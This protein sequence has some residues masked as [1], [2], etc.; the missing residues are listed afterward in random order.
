M[1]SGS[2]APVLSDVM[3][4]E[5]EVSLR[6]A[7]HL[8]SH[9]KS[10][11]SA[12]VAID[13]AHVRVHGNEVFPLRSFL[14]S[15]GW[16]PVTALD[17]AL[18]Q[19]TYVKGQKKILITTQSGIGDVVIDVGPKTIRAECKKGPLI[20]KKGSPEYPLVRGAIG[21][22]MTIE[23]APANNLLVVAVPLTERFRK[24]LARWRDRPLIQR[25]G[26]LLVAVG[27]SETVEGLPPL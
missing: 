10:G 13:G 6:L 15:Q 14:E 7:F 26:I 1:S 18:W 5:A 23:D 17:A 2:S 25:T 12:T 3:M 19:G 21:Q 11:P 20:P 24:L 16:S 27:R 9:P 4:A 8:L 22:L